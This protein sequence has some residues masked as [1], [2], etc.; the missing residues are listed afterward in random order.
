MGLEFD[1]S[2]LTNRLDSMAKKMQN[3]TLDKAL[4]EGKK[5]VIEAMENNALVD[6]GEL[7]SS[8]GEIKKKGSGAGR[9]SVIGIDSEDRNVIERGY[10]AEYGTECQAAAHWMKKSF[11]EA[12][13]QAKDKIIE[14]LKEELDL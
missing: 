13:E 9:T 8:I 7:A 6:T 4:D 10:Y 1:F 2:A 11:N 5:P 12:K 3:S 14:T